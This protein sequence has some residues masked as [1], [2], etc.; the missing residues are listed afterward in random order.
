VSRA[1]PHR[2]G[3]TQPAGPTQPA[4]PKP[5]PKPIPAVGGEYI[6]AVITD[7]AA[8]LGDSE[9]TAAHRAEARELWRRSGLSE[10]DFARALLGVRERVTRRS[11]SPRQ[12]QPGGNARTRMGAFFLLLHD[13][14]GMPDMTGHDRVRLRR[15]FGRPPPAYLRRR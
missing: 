12:P 8:E 6:D 9:H 1:S 4:L 14:L 5:V 15:G 2:M 10:G 7:T 13:E 3:S 11:R